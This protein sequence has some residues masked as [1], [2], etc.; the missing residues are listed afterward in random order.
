MSSLDISP[1]GRADELLREELDDLPAEKEE[2]YEKALNRLRYART[3]HLVIRIL[4]YAGLVTSVAAEFGL[5]LD[6]VA[7]IAS[8]IGL[9]F[10]GVIYLVTGY[11]EK[12]L[13]EEFE[14]RRILMV[15]ASS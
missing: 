1:L 8:F 12:V 7:R 15:K 4:L 3:F 13:R 2:E 9:T 14:V 6:W 10:L 5:Q 11:V